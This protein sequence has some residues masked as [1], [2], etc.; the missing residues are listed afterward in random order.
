MR[1]NYKDLNGYLVCAYNTTGFCNMLNVVYIF[2]VARTWRHKGLG[3]RAMSLGLHAM[4]RKTT[5][6]D[7]Q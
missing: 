1:S 6:E 3:V 2:G 4:V 7:K 5:L